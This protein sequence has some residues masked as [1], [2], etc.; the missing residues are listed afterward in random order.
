M[1]PNNL[2]FVSTG[3]PTIY[4]TYPLVSIDLSYAISFDIHSGIQK[5][6][7]VYQFTYP[8]DILYLSMYILCIL[9]TYPETSFNLSCWIFYPDSAGLACHCVQRLDRFTQAIVFIYP[10]IRCEPGNRA[11]QPGDRA[12]LYHRDARPSWV[13]A[14]WGCAALFGEVAAATA[15][16]C[17]HVQPPSRVKYSGQSSND[18]VHHI[19]P[20]MAAGCKAGGGRHATEE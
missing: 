12:P 10:H 15:D 6:I 16:R 2:S 14:G 1:I 18:D 17:C 11:R 7:H 5:L 20:P 9:C 4:P 3:Y 8:S 13:A 19:L